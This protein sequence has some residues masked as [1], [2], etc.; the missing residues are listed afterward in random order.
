MTKQCIYDI[1]HYRLVAYTISSSS[2]ILIHLKPISRIHI[3]F[4]RIL[5]IDRTIGSKHNLR[6]PITSMEDAPPNYT[7]YLNNLNDK[8]KID[9]MK[10]SLY[11]TF[12][13]HGK[14]LEIGMGKAR[15]L[16]GQ[17]WVTFDD[18]PSATNALRTL[19]GFV[20]FEKPIAIQFAKQK[21]D[22]IAQREGTYKPREKRKR[23]QKPDAG[24][25]KKNSIEN[26]DHAPTTKRAPPP[27]PPQ[28]NLPNKILFLQA[29][30]ESC[31]KEMLSV[32]FEQ[33][34]GFQVCQ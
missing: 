21:A 7:L 9:R 23:D 33:Y 2:I 20:V 12:S 13:Q 17:A 26:G 5:V 30:P 22:V 31:T 10:A 8:I 4:K 29:L 15:R 19:N 14:I 3:D 32:L 25:S 28:H 34:H 18:I 1:N 24:N 16:R 27:P 6:M 11:S